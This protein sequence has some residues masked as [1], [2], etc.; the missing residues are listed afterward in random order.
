MSDI[1][2][3]ILIAS[4][5]IVSPGPG[6]LLT[7]S[8]SINYRMSNALWGIGGVV[9]GMGIIGSIASSSLGAILIASPYALN[10]VKIIGA[11]YLL[12]LGTKLFRSKPKGL[13]DGNSQSVAPA[14]HKLFTEALTITLFNPKPIVFFMALFP[15]FIDT[16]HPVA[17]QFATL[18]IIFCCLVFLI[19]FIYACFAQIARR[20]LTGD[21]FFII[22]NRIAG[23]V[24]MV[25]GLM[26]GLSVF[27]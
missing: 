10:V 7:L 13:G 22:L 20:K 15:Q 17:I 5:T 14:G 2:V 9:I 11:A 26:L 6:I 19:H 4:L 27:A 25:F 12:Y 8:N 18:L 3:Y 1:L 23:C 24:F 16:T 21:N